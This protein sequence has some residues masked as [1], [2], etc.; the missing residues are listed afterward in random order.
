MPD[1]ER[2]TTRTGLVF[3]TWV[4]GPTDGP[5]VLL[6]HGFLQSRHTWRDQ[7]PALAAAGFRVVAPDQR[8]YSP[9]ARP[10]PTELANYAFDRLIDDVL[11]LADA[12]GREQRRF[13]LIGHDWGGQVAWGVA[14]RRPDRLASLA[15][16]SR[17]HPASFLEAL[18][19]P[20]GDQS[21]RSRHHRA[22]L[23][24]STGPTLL[25]NDCRRLRLMLADAGVPPSA[26]DDYVSVLRDPAAMEAALAWYRAL[27][28]LRTSVGAISV[29]TLYIWGDADQTVGRTAAEGTSRHVNGPFR[30]V[31]LPGVGHFVTDEA[32]DTVNR[33]LVEHLSA[34]P[35]G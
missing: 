18:Q 19:A 12:L 34:H 16:L 1:L 22:F 14:A 2:I 26:I 7:V 25:A 23:D 11:D 27:P 13:H 10:D 31:V 17:P 28:Q 32:A 8:G 4:A 20:D 30:F 3:D 21:H 24:A 6:L 9:G 15:I 33:L 35:A 29:P 5:L